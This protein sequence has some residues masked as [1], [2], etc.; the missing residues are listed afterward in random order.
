MLPWVVVTMQ[1]LNAFCES[2]LSIRARFP[3][4]H[5]IAERALEHR[6]SSHQ[7][8]PT[9]PRHLSCWNI[10]SW[11]YPKPPPRKQQNEMGRQKAVEERPSAA[12]RDKMEWR[13]RRNL[14]TASTRGNSVPGE[15]KQ[16][17][18]TRSW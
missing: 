11:Q 15:P 10:N 3:T 14:G 18:Q 17:N 5:W 2:P 13:S 4:G 1:D 9:R 7:G 8:L 16:L 6:L 12:T